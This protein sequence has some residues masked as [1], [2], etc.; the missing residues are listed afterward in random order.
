MFFF[1]WGFLLWLGVT[2][3]VRLV[4]HF[5][6]NA[7]LVL[8]IFAAAVPLIA[9]V[10]YPVYSWR[11]LKPS[12]RPLAAIYA[13]LPGMV[14]D[15]FVLLFFSQVFPNLPSTAVV[16]YAAW[17]FWGYSLGLLT[18]FVPSPLAILADHFSRQ[19]V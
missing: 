9:A 10:A 16:T 4:G 6:L 13:V 1:V 5:L 7:T 11:K 12:Q 19:A 14:L 15:V 8:L 17:L 2:V 3:T 18:G